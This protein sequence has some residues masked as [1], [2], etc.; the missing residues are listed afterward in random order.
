MLH[1]IPREEQEAYSRE[2]Y[3]PAYTRR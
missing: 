2:E 3:Y 1:G